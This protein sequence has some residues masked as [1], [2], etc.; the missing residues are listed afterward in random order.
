M[1]GFWSERPLW[2]TPCSERRCTIPLPPRERAGTRVLPR[3]TGALQR[4]RRGEQE[5]P[6][7]SDTPPLQQLECILHDAERA[8]RQLQRGL[9]VLRV[10]LEPIAC[11]VECSELVNLG[12][13]R[14]EGHGLLE[15]SE[16]L[17]LSSRVRRAA[18]SLQMQTEEPVTASCGLAKTATFTMLDS[19][20]AA[21]RRARWRRWGTS[22][23]RRA[24]ARAPHLDAKGARWARWAR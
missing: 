21:P 12:G 1:D 13:L 22:A 19:R 8:V 2:S 10:G 15:G 6:S 4:C 20:S 7:S 17:G 18:P 23:A 24:R 14:R 5:T 11:M 9:R 3:A 16:K